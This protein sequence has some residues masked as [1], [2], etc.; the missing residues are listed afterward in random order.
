MGN[1]FFEANLMRNIM[2][3]P[4]QKMMEV[5]QQYRQIKQ[6][7]NMLASV[8]QQKGMISE[9]QVKDIQQMGSNYAQVGEYLMQNGK[10]P[11]NIQQYEGQVNQVQSML[12]NQKD[13]S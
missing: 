1:S 8:L 2:P 13:I 7:P 3:S 10:M 12:N 4:M 6:N 11:T 5:M 9:Q